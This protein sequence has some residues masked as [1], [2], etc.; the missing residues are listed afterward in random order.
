M[1]DRQISIHIP[2]DQSEFKTSLHDN[3]ILVY[4]V[5]VK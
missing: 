4:I 2:A 3:S 1:Q 5:A